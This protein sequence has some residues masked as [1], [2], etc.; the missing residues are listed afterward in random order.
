M[1]P[2]VK[3]SAGQETATQTVDRINAARAAGTAA[4]PEGNA[5]MQNLE[6]TLLGQADLVSS[7]NTGI[8]SAIQSAI[9]SVEQQR[10]ASTGRI[11]GRFDR[12]ESEVLR[13]GVASTVNATEAR[14][15][16]A[17]QTAVL[18][19]IL[20]TTNTELGKLSDQRE[21]LI[22]QGEAEAASQISGLMVQQA[23]MKQEAQ[24]QT[25]QNM[26]GIG[27]FLQG[28]QQIQLQRDQFKQQVK[29]DILTQ[30]QAE[31][32]NS[33]AEDQFAL[34]KSTNE[35]DRTMAA[36]NLNI[37][38]S[39]LALSQARLAIAQG[40]VEDKIP[41]SPGFMDLDTEGT[42]RGLVADHLADI[43]QQLSM[44]QIDDEGSVA[45]KLQKVTE[46]QAAYGENFVTTE[47]LLETMG[48]PVAETA[49]ASRALAEE[50]F[51]AIAEAEQFAIDQ[52][53]IERGQI[54]QETIPG[55]VPFQ[56][57]VFAPGS[58]GQRTQSF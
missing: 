56:G 27:G 57:G 26:L 44:G 40:E 38:K 30:S 42:I 12:L 46:L 21:E 50:E 9:G 13:S 37:R 19:N 4:E 2:K 34:D 43:N 51:T 49:E 47:A 11:S 14:R 54:A 32:N 15:G 48:L 10:E 35:F 53:R 25:F 39:E 16:F 8:E 28:N 18:R 29:R 7:G 17:T 3:T 1:E 52:A 31:F 58:A 33:M 23:Q 55:N 36:E 6:K 20:D 24:Q 45:L 22:L 41:P 5:V